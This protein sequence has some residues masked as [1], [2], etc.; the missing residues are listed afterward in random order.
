MWLDVGF[1]RDFRK[2][3]MDFFR[4]IGETEKTER[5]IADTVFKKVWNLNDKTLSSAAV[6]RVSA[7]DWEKKFW[8]AA[9]LAGWVPLTGWLEREAATSKHARLMV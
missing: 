7:F 6:C 8:L 2:E 4:E 5:T 1:F 3:S 9:W